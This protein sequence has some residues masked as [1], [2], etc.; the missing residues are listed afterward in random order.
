MTGLHSHDLLFLSHLVFF[1]VFF[2]MAFFPHLITAIVIIFFLPHLFISAL[3]SVWKYCL[4][5]L[6]SVCWG[7]NCRLMLLYMIAAILFLL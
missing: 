6:S 4:T 2:K 3:I 1:P 5:M 7:E